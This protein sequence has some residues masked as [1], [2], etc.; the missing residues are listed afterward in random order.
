MADQQ[1]GA[2]DDVG[3]NCNVGSGVNRSNV[4]GAG[5]ANNVDN[6][7]DPQA[8]WAMTNGQSID[9]LRA[10]LAVID[11]GFY[12]AARLNTMTVNDMQYAVRLNDRPT[13]IKQ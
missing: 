12:T 10:R 2:L 9:D 7:A 13:S 5:N 4:N 3:P 1:I 11:A 8:G 6:G